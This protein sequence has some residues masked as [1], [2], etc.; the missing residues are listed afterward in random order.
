MDQKYS[1]SFANT[2]QSTKIFDKK[3]IYNKRFWAVFAL[4]TAAEK[5][6]IFCKTRKIEGSFLSMKIKD[7]RVQFFN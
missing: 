5:F 4:N 6:N 3:Y 1:L 2:K 7:L